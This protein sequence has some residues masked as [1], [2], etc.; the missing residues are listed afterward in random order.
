MVI[1][2]PISSDLICD[3]LRVV[4]DLFKIIEINI[5]GSIGTLG[6]SFFALF[7]FPNEY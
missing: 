7:L 6:H 3:N 4:E 1:S 2:V 5:V